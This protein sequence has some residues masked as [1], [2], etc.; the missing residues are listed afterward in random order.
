MIGRVFNG[1]Y[2]ITERIGIGGMA[3]V[4]KAQ[5]Q[6]LGRTV[7]VKV[8][9]PQYAA[10]PE[11]TARFKQEA[12]SAA[13]LQSPYIVNVYDWGQDDGTYFIVMEFVRGTDLKSA[14][15]QRG[16]INQRKVAEIG[17]QVCQALSVAHG[18]DIIHRDIKPQNIMVQ[19]DGNVKVMDFGIA[20]AKNS[21]KTQTSSVL[22]TAHYISPEQAQGKELDGTSDM[23]S[24]G[25]VLYEAAT[26]QLPFDGPDAVS[27][28]M[29][30]VNEP[31][32]PPSQVKPD[33]HPDLEAIILKAMEKNPI[34]RFRTAREMKHALDDFLMGRPVNL[35]EGINS[36]ATQVMNN[37]VPPISNADIPGGTAV[38]PAINGVNG[39]SGPM[40]SV[41]YRSGNEFDMGKKKNTGRTVGIVIGALVALLAI[42]GIALFVS[43]AFG[44]QAKVPDVTG[45][46]EEAA[47]AAIE[48]AGY[49][50]GEI[51]QENSADT[52][53]GR[54]IRTDPAADTELAKG[55]TVNIVISLGAKKNSVPNLSGMTADQAQ[56]AIED[57][58]FVAK[59]GGN[60]N[61]D[62]DKNTVSRQ[63]PAAGQEKDEGTTI[64]YWISTGPEMGNVPNVIGND[65]AT[66]T[67]MLEDAGFIVSAQDGG[68]S[69]QYEEGKVM[70][71]EPNGGQLE[72]GGTVTIYISQ[73]KDPAT[74]PVSV[75]AVTGLDEGSAISELNGAGFYNVGVS[76]ET[77]NTVLEGK[78]IRQTQSGKAT[79]DTYIEIVV[80]AGPGASAG[81]IGDDGEPIN[82][83]SAS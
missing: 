40:K 79:T 71:Q 26:G 15:Q 27:V 70:N 48:Q 1:R 52:V 50:V 38:M 73:G 83:G 80:S 32:V 82:S 30:Q 41:D 81:N 55:E 75:P 47:R 76:Y 78:V 37:V 42:A 68:Y 14:I 5:D 45:Q 35:G 10:D 6:V 8:M 25:C 21:V 4:Y 7:A 12:A 46:T 43:G 60:E 19:P 20:R 2:R 57:A 56:K 51:S 9:L 31:P 67:K 53:S 66:A 59:F 29:R 13:N 24:L 44:G 64:T 58:G 49:T 62:A 3:E 33:I 65:R 36:A 11:F 69:D 22:G 63:D 16:A 72:E 18:L 28:A 23:Y 17:S 54:V 39:N 34:N 77:S 74:I 61:S